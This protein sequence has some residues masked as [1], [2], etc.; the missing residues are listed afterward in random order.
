MDD[1]IKQE[2][3]ILESYDFSIFLVEEKLCSNLLTL[4]V[5]SVLILL[6][7]SLDLPD[8][9]S[10]F[11]F[12]SVFCI[13]RIAFLVC[14]LRIKSKVKKMGIDKHLFLDDRE[15][16]SAASITEFFNERRSWLLKQYKNNKIDPEFLKKLYLRREVR[17]KNL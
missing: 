5:P 1:F 12:V 16:E 4:L 6:S 2:I 11:L 9:I 13:F 14:H 17:W 3:K 7:L 8:L 15:W 10:F